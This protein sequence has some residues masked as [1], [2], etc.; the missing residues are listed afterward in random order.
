MGISPSINLTKHRIVTIAI[1]PRLSD[2]TATT[3]FAAATSALINITPLKIQNPIEIHQENQPELF[4]L[5]IIK[6]NNYNFITF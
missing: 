1:R 4:S 5:S 3:A 6:S 2:A